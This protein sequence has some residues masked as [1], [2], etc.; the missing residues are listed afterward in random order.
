MSPV[1]AGKLGPSNA[2]TAGARSPIQLVLSFLVLSK[3]SG[4]IPLPVPSRDSRGRATWEGQ[5][6][7]GG[8]VW[9]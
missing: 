3:N 7:G 1:I 8:R 2:Q 5:R 6:E 9:M 4:C